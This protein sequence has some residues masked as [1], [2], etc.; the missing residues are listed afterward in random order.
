[1]AVVCVCVCV[2]GGQ[3]LGALNP[4][5]PASFL[6]ALPFLYIRKTFKETIILFLKQL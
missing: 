5:P 4:P 2:V 3:S 6:S 1:M